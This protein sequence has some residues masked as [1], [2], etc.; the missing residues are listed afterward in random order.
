MK[1]ADNRQKNL[2]LKVGTQNAAVVKSVLSQSNRIPIIN[3]LQ[4]KREA[5]LSAQES[6]DK[7]ARHGTSAYWP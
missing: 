7:S 1:Q 4:D 2:A 3:K 6:A 5:S